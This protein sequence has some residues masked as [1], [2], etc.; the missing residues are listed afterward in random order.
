MENNFLYNKAILEKLLEVASK[1][2]DLGFGQLLVTTDIL[3]VEECLCD[4]EQTTLAIK[5]IIDER[6]EL[7]WKRMCENKICFD[8]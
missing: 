2:P 1:Y 6:S 3:E 4:V 7:I 5:D 8:Y